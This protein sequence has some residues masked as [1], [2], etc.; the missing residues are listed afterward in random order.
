MRSLNFVRSRTLS[1]HGFLP[2]KLRFKQATTRLGTALIRSREEWSA[3][4]A[5]LGGGGFLLLVIL[6]LVPNS[7]LTFAWS[8]RTV[9]YLTN[10]GFTRLSLFTTA[11]L[12]CAIVASPARRW[13]G[14]GSM[15]RVGHRAIVTGLVLR[16]GATL[17]IHW[18]PS[19]GGEVPQF[20]QSQPYLSLNP[21]VLT[22]WWLAKW[23]FM[24]MPIGMFLFSLGIL[25]ANSRQR[26]N[27]FSFFLMALSS[28]CLLISA[29]FPKIGSTVTLFAVGISISSLV[30][31]AQGV[32]TVLVNRTLTYSLLTFSIVTLYAFVIITL[33]SLFQTRGHL[34]M[35]LVATGVIAV[36]FQP[37]RER[38]QRLVNRFMYGERDD[39]YTVVAR[40][41]QRLESTLQPEAVL[42]TIV[43]T[44][45]EAL[46][47]PY[48]AIRIQRGDELVEVAAIGT[49]TA[50][51]IT[52]PLLYQHEPVGELVLSPRAAEERFNQADNR[53]LRDLARQA[54]VAVHAVRLTGELQRARARLVTTREE[55][56]RRLRRDLHDGLGPVLASQ[57]LTIGAACH[58]I[59][60]EPDKAVTLLHALKEQTQEALADIRRVV[61]DLRPP[62]LDE[63][64]LVGALRERMTTLQGSGLKATLVAPD[65]LPPL[66]AAVEVA[67]YRIVLEAVTNVLHHAQAT[68]CQIEMAVGNGLTLTVVD[69]GRGLPANRHVG[70]GLASMRERAEELGGTW[71]IEPTPGG[72]ATVRVCLPLPK[73]ELWSEFA[74]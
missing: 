18:N 54:G 30:F 74:S 33:S 70:V 26:I 3:L 14:G 22:S 50:E 61:Y 62:A 19:L 23:S 47:V 31:V 17:L 29:L 12:L 11:L 2:A 16:C 71:A 28:L 1:G 46:K 24:L 42:P 64:G 21:S 65:P 68:T 44:V 66:S 32:M 67:V 58:L 45:R 59:K 10:D 60:Q 37:I 9:P 15:I 27:A 7:Y 20:L 35:S 40:L 43:Q 49:S 48:V 73:E 56:R 53:L 41:G 6:R 72:G 36:A 69:D 63:L 8:D 39:P 52:L 51:Q 5:I 34:W 13:A 57:V 38:S 4:A 25:R 55:E